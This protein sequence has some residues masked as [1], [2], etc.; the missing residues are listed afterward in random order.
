MYPGEMLWS[1]LGASM[2]GGAHAAAYPRHKNSERRSE[3]MQ[4]RALPATA[5]SGWLSAAVL[6][7]SGCGAAP[8]GEPATVPDIR[9]VAMGDYEPVLD[10]PKP[11]PDGD[12]PHDG[13]TW[14]SGAGVWAERPDKV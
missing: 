5:L 12:L 2:A 4:I 11:L 3:T 9:P 13:W 10:W 1:E 8:E 6:T 14:G 7:L